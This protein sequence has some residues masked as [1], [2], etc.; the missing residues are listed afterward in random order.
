MSQT[1]LIFAGTTFTPSTEITKYKNLTDVIPNL[2]FSF[3][4][5]VF[6]YLLQD[7]F[8]SLPIL[9]GSVAKNK[10]IIHHAYNPF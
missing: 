7:R 8:E 10:N 6:A 4:K 9:V 5:V 1:A 2:H 3:F